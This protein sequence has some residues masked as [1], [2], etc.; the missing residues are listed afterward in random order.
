MMD[1]IPAL[2]FGQ[3]AIKGHVKVE[4]F[5]AKTRELVRKI[6]KDNLVTSALAKLINNIA[7]GADGQID[8]MVMPIATKALGGIM[9]FD[10]TLTADADNVEFPSGVSLLGYGLRDV[11]TS[12]TKRGSLNAAESGAIYN[13]YRSVWD[14]GTSQ[15]NGTIAS[16]ALMNSAASPFVGNA[17]LETHSIISAS[18]GNENGAGVFHTDGDYVY[19]AS[20]TGSYTSEYDRDT[21]ITTYTHTITVT[22]FR[23]RIP[24]TA[25][26]VADPINSRSY[27]EQLASQSF[28]IVTTN[29]T[30][31]N[32]SS[33]TVVV[34]DGK[35][36][37]AYFVY[38]ASNSSGSC[39]IRYF[40][41]KYSD[42][43]FDASEVQTIS[44]PGVYLKAGNGVVSGGY[45]YLIAND[46]HGIYRFQ[47]SNTANV[48]LFTLPAGFYFSTSGNEH[49]AMAA[50]PSGGL[51]LQL[52]TAAANGQSGY[53]DHYNAIMNAN[54]AI[55]LDGAYYTRNQYTSYVAGIAGYR[56]YAFMHSWFFASG[57]LNLYP[58]SG[59]PLT[60]YLGTIANLAQPVVKNASQTLKVT[61]TLTDAGA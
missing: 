23:E 7:G 16:V 56:N 40:T 17:P 20:G 59:R 33:P 47:L 54:G 60:N 13:G 48:Q 34:C 46:R 55:T 6:E 24:L 22:I 41:I 58:Y 19:W 25:Y 61:Y 45:L 36:G 8:D 51:L 14:F 5:D 53:Y 10:G 21:R 49:K 37:Y 28:T 43:S 29:Y 57:N 50:N 15:A 1:K 31:N 3:P 9:L 32:Y 35:D 30:L 2:R 27:P 42:L 11:N 4:L 12:N 18:G 38:A 26:K 39:D 44:S 52:Y